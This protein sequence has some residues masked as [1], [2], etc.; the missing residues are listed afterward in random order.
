MTLKE[1]AMG[2]YQAYAT[3]IGSAKGPEDFFGVLSGDRDAMKGQVQRLYRSTARIMH[4]DFNGGAAEANAIFSRLNELWED[5][6]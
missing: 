1:K 6:K 4:P 5:A 3:R 2:D